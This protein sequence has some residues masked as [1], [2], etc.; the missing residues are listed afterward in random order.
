MNPYYA[1]FRC[2]AVAFALWGNRCQSV[3]LT[4]ADGTIVEC[5]NPLFVLDPDSWWHENDLDAI[6]LAG[7]DPERIARGLR[8]YAEAIHTA[9]IRV[10]RPAR[11]D[12]GI[13]QIRRANK[14]KPHPVL[15]EFLRRFDLTAGRCKSRIRYLLA[16][17]DYFD[18]TPWPAGE[19]AIAKWEGRD[20]SSPSA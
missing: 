18:G 12:E 10:N 7:P 15:T 13:R 9:H 11:R 17:M 6:I 8:R 20:A 4:D 14:A 1:E 3:A 2:L 19:E 16:R 5:K